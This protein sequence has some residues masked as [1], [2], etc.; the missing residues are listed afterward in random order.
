MDGTGDH[1]DS[2]VG[3]HFYPDISYDNL[4]RKIKSELARKLPPEIVKQFWSKFLPELRRLYKKYQQSSCSRV[5]AKFRDHVTL[6]VRNP[7]A[8]AAGL[9]Q[10]LIDGTEDGNDAARGFL[11][12]RGINWDEFCYQIFT[13]L[14]ER[15]PISIGD[16]DWLEA[17]KAIKSMYQDY[18]R[19]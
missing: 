15:V 16:R 6:H 5:E 19:G 7:D 8:G 12:S 1:W 11:F 13:I 14:S 18:C 17:K 2:S 4:R 10:V 3:H 9:W